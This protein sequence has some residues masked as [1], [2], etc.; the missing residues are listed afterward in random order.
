M[1]LLLPATS[2]TYIHSMYN[3]IMKSKCINLQII[4]LKR[5]EFKIKIVPKNS[6]TVAAHGFNLGF[7][8]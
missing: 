8:K 1:W 4:N 7:C 6:K 5:L 2:V 3:T